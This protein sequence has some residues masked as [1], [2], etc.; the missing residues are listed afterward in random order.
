[1]DTPLLAQLHE[2]LYTH[3][4][5][6]AEAIVGLIYALASHDHAQSVVELSLNSLFRHGY[7][8]LY[9]AIDAFA[10]QSVDLR[11]LA[12]VV[13]PRPEGRHFWLMS[14][15]VTAYPRPYARTL[16]DRSYVYA[17]TPTPGQKPVKVGHAYTST[18]LLPEREK[19]APPWVIPLDVRRVPSDADA[20]LAGAQVLQ[21]LLDDETMPWHGELV[22]SVQDSKYSKPAYL[23]S[24][25]SYENLVTV[26]RVRTNRVFYRRFEPPPD[27]PKRRGRLRRYGD[28]F[29]LREPETWHEPDAACTLEGVTARGKPYILDV[30]AWHNMLM[31]GRRGEAMYHH[32]FTLIQV[33]M[34]DGAGRSLHKRPLWL[35]LFGV[36]RHDV[37]LADA[38]KAYLQRFDHEHF[39]RFGKRRLLL[40]AFQTPD[41]RREEAWHRLVSLAY[42]FLW[43]ARPTAQ[44][45]WRPWEKH[46]QAKGDRILSP[47]Q[48]QRDFARIIRA[49]GLQPAKPKPRGKSPG[50]PTG[51]RQKPRKRH[52]VVKK[53]SNLRTKRKKAA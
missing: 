11:R 28:R 52:P 47:T 32:P 1:M 34:R 29:A 45:R 14:T 12:A 22:V 19:G 49:L 6:R 21:T 27:A 7:A 31:R 38:V 9:R 50:R 5:K 40:T 41:V 24:L 53:S 46:L 48:V 37:A 33:V 43:A 3:L 13:A 16:E 35:I 51:Y 10:S 30:Q 26:V 8:S 23:A 15:D 17:P 18:L 39:F 25:T 36:R 4:D 42:L 44:Q 2:T 20:E